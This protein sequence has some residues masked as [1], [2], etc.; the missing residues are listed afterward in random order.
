MKKSA[1]FTGIVAGG[2][3]VSAPAFAVEE[4]KLTAASGL[5][6]FSAGTGEVINVFIPEVDKRLA[7]K[8]N[9]KIVW[10]TGWGGAIANQFEL[11]E[12]VQDGLAD[13]GYVNTL[14][15]GAKL[16]M[17]Q[18]TYVTP[19][20]AEDL[21]AIYEVFNEVRGKMPEMD[22]AYV[23]NNQYRKAIYGL[24]TYHFQTTFPIKT[25]KDIDGRKFGTPGL[26]ANW[27]KNTGAIS[28]AGSLSQYYNSLKTGVYD[29]IVIFESGIG[30]FKFFE[31]APIITKVG[32]GSQVAS[33]LTINKDKW[34][35]LPEEV[36]QVID[37]VSVVWQDAAKER[38]R[39]DASKSMATATAG[40]AT[41]NELP[42]EE[43][44]KLANAIPNI[45]KEWA[46]SIDDKGLPGTRLLETYMQTWRD[47]GVQH[48]RAW[49]KE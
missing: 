49:D 27:I 18:V 11:F 2:L 9:Y 25:L 31:V 46:K 10:T 5:P 34:E 26:A 12:A 47:R 29:G 41:V 13:I 21:D 14:F 36:R 40:G 15:E 28:V 48:A 1:F 37:E 23:K 22:A 8:G 16:P 24:T 33:N 19:F 7:A 38:G 17:D 43:V 39:N 44:V 4:I 35:S 45:A 3:A 20:G 42:R 6:S 32:I 30:P